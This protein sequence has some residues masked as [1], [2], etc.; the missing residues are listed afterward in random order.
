MPHP[1]NCKVGTTLRL[2]SA[3]RERQAAESQEQF[4]LRGG[5]LRRF[6]HT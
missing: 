6:F 5:P 3:E 2:L 1:A 4:P